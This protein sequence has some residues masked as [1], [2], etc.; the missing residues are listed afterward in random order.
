MLKDVEANKNAFVRPGIKPH[1]VVKRAQN[2]GMVKATARLIYEVLTKQGCKVQKCKPLTGDVKA[3]K[4]NMALFRLYTKWEG[5]C[6]EDQRDAAL[7]ALFR[8]RR[9]YVY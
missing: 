5:R 7:L 8:Y 6:N 1:Q 3:A 4:K 9:T 2:V